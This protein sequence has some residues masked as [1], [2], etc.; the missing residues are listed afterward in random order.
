LPEWSLAAF[1]R[2]QMTIK[3]NTACHNAQLASEQPKNVKV[4]VLGDSTPARS[5]ETATRCLPSR[6]PGT[7]SCANAVIPDEGVP[8]DLG[9]LGEWGLAVGVSA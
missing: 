6:S 1:P 4:Q 7:N 2:A 8:G 3:S 5:Q 9:F